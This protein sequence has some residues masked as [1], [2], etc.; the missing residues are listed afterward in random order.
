MNDRLIRKN[1]FTSPRVSSL[2]LTERFLLVGLAS[3][4]DARGN[5]WNNPESIKASI[6]GG[7]DNPS[8]QEIAA[9]MDNLYQKDYITIYEGEEGIQYYHIN[10]W[11]KKGSILY[12][13]LMHQAPDTEIPI[14]PDIEDDQ[15]LGKRDS[16]LELQ[17]YSD[18]IGST[19]EVNGKEKNGI[20]DELKG[21]EVK[22][23]FNVMGIDLD[24][25]KDADKE[26]IYR[27][28][29]KRKVIEMYNKFSQYTVEPVL[30]RF[31]EWNDSNPEKIKDYDS[32]FE[33]WCYKDINTQG[34]QNPPEMY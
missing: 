19:S 12:Q 27:Y 34:Q 26:S 14:C 9:A 7:L 3:Y 15:Y 2:P 24:F 30:N 17:E 21:R 29:T 4:A 13:K 16:L 23:K 11:R 10:G 28:V 1:F 6:F 5:G 32:S 20:E 31:N 33:H 8:T 18:R 22:T 25:S